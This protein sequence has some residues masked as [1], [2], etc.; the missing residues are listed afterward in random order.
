MS[1]V[2]YAP[3]FSS[4]FTTG[5]D[6]DGQGL[7]S[8]SDATGANVGGIKAISGKG[9]GNATTQSGVGLQMTVANTNAY[10]MI[11]SAD[12]QNGEQQLEMYFFPNGSSN[13][14]VSAELR[15]QRVHR[16]TQRAKHLL[17]AR[18]ECRRGQH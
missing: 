10:A 11:S 12:G 5:I 17:P 7:W 6:L 18:S 1:T 8:T 15:G 14:G 16:C 4:G 9:Y 2:I 3:N 13:F